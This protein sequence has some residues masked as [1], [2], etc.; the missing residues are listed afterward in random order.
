MLLLFALA[1][2]GCALFSKGDVT[3]PRFFAPSAA[4][5][6]FEPHVTAYW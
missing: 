1:G 3:E 5:N 4:R 2:S 6:S